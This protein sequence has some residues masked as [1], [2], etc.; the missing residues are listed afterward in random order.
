MTQIYD[1]A[2]DP[3]INAAV[4][5][6]NSCLAQFFHDAEMQIDADGDK[7]YVDVEY[8]R[9]Y[10][11]GDKTNIPTRRATDADREMYRHAY[12]QFL[13]DKSAE[14][15]PEGFPI[16][17]WKEATPAQTMMLKAQNIVVV[18]ALAAVAETALAKVPQGLYLQAEARKFLELQAGMAET[19]KLRRELSEAEQVRDALRNTNEELRERLER[20]ETENAGNGSR[21]E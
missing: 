21:V 6:Q 2:A 17:K 9:I 12:E 16:A 4:K 15:L 3:N 5:G 7:V 8:L 11:P 14:Q 20:Y 18:E 1:A 19:A 10:I 13:K